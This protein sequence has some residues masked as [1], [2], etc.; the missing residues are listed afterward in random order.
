MGREFHP[1]FRIKL[2]NLISNT[3]EIDI[4][5]YANQESLRQLKYLRMNEVDEFMKMRGFENIEQ[6]ET[7]WEICLMV[8]VKKE[9]L[10]EVNHVNKISIAKGFGGMFGNKGGVAYSF[11]LRDRYFNFI[12][13]HLIHKIHKYQLR[14]LMISELVQQMQ[15]MNLQ[16]T[17]V[18]PGVQ[19]DFISDFS[20][21]LGDLNYRLETTFAQLN[22]SNVEAEVP[23]LIEEK[24]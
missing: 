10:H 2:S 11:N 7:M 23:K 14:N 6:F 22:S 8:F 4:V 9:L 3:E 15:L 20:F 16:K 13:C 21:I 24:E 5:V 18:L 12:C 19:S 1:D 17:G